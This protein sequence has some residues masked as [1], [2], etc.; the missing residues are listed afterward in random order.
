M[1]CTLC[2]CPC[3]S[4]QSLQA[5]T[6][7]R[8]INGPL[9]NLLVRRFSGERAQICIRAFLAIAAA[10]LCSYSLLRGNTCEHTRTTGANTGNPSANT[11]KT[12]A[13]PNRATIGMLQEARDHE[14]SV[15]GGTRSLFGSIEATIDGPSMFLS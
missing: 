14:A 3:T 4:G 7:I 13:N 11:R 6:F 9:G 5:R 12:R 10:S 2:D 1:A 8:Y 15:F